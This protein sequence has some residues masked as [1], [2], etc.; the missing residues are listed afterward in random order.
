MDIDAII[1]SIPFAIPFLSPLNS[2]FPFQPHVAA[3]GGITHAGSIKDNSTIGIMN[4][5][6]NSWS[7]VFPPECIFM[8]VLYCR[9]GSKYFFRI[10]VVPVLMRAKPEPE[11][12]LVKELQ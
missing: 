5:D 7:P 4:T 6:A 1:R 12:E 9:Q 8:A 11:L 10:M 3:G 2:G